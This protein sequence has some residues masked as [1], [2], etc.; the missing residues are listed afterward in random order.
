MCHLPR[1]SEWIIFLRAIVAGLPILSHGPFET[2]RTDEAPR[3]FLEQVSNLSIILLDGETLHPMKR[4]YREARHPPPAKPSLFKDLEGARA[5]EAV[6]AG[7]NP[8]WMARASRANL[9]HSRIS[10]G[11]GTGEAA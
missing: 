3:I 5:G 7:S 4:I 10:D 1:N 9:L 6:G 8:F 2:S 11:R